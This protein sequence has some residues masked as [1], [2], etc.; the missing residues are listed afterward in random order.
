MSNIAAALTWTK[1]KH[2]PSAHE[3]SIEDLD[4]RI[5]RVDDIWFVKTRRGGSP[6]S[7]PGDNPIYLHTLKAAKAEVQRVADK[8]AA[9]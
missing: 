8:V 3:T 7:H 5:V 2:E 6:F 4:V 1:S 9:R